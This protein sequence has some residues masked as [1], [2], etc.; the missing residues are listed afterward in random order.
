M[1]R[2]LA[3]VATKGKM[4]HGL[5][6]RCAAPALLPEWLNIADANQKKCGSMLERVMRTGETVGLIELCAV[7]MASLYKTTRLFMTCRAVNVLFV[8]KTIRAMTRKEMN[9]G[10]TLTIVIKPKEF[11]AFCA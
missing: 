8:L 3:Q 1:K 4:G 9:A 2:L 11:A 6:T 10:W 7:T 5:N